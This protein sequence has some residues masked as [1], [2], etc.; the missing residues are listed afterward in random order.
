MPSA[1]S[2]SIACSTSSSIPISA[3]FT[4]F[5]STRICATHLGTSNLD[6][7]SLYSILNPPISVSSISSKAT[8]LTRDNSDST[9][10]SF[11]ILDIEFSLPN[12]I[13]Y[14]PLQRT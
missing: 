7:D 9:C 8:T 11:I 4:R 14:I 13:F 10:N 12:D 5:L 6:S 2:L 3:S 1:F